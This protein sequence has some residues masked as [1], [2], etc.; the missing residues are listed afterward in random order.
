MVLANGVGGVRDP[1]YVQMLNRVRTKGFDDMPVEFRELSPAY[2]TTDPDGVRQWLELHRKSVTA[3]RTG[4]G[5]ERDHSGGA[6]RDEIPDAAD[7]RRRRSHRLLPAL[8]LFARYIPD[9]SE[10]PWWPRPD[11]RCIRNSRRYSI[12]WC[13]TSLDGIEANFSVLCRPLLRLLD[14]QFRVR[15]MGLGHLG[16]QYRAA[17]RLGDVQ[18]TVGDPP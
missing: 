9:N 15:N 1:D 8:R 7:D 11:I 14:M 10:P 5:G 13:S 18:P 4:H 17:R 6:A 12:A 2:R 16:T 3:K